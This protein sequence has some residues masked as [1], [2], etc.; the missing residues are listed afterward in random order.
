[1]SDIDAGAPPDTPTE[2]APAEP[3][4]VEAPGFDDLDSEYDRIG[5]ELDSGQITPDAAREQ[6][7][8]L[9]GEHKK[10]RERYKPAADVFGRLDDTDADAFRSFVADY[11]SDDPRERGRAVG[12]L[13]QSLVNMIGGP[14]EF[15][16]VAPEMFRSIAPNLF[17]QQQAAQPSSP[18]DDPEWDPYDKDALDKMLDERF[19]QRYRERRESEQVEQQTKKVLELVEELGY[20]ARSP[21]AGALLMEAQRRGGGFDQIRAVHEEMAAAEKERIEA[22]ILALAEPPPTAPNGQPPNTNEDPGF[23]PNNPGAWR[24]RA[25]ASA[26]SRIADNS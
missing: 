23:D 9:A 20:D 4:E 16:K 17:A 10:Y 11:S 6:L 1:M 24:N 5:Q 2:P 15:E 18:S 8:R 14:D 7:N 25:R 22:A 26:L 21:Q 13:A 3:T 19:E 12:F